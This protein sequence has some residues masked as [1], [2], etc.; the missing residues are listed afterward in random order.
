MLPTASIKHDVTDK[1]SFGIIFEKPF[2]A[3]VAYGPSSIL[4]AGTTASADT[5]SITALFRYKFSDRISIHGG[6]C[7]QSAEA[8]FGLTGAIYGPF[9]GYTANMARDQRLGYVVG[10]A[11]EIP[12]YFLRVALTYSSEIEHSFTTTETSLFGALVS[13]VSA[14]TPQ[15]INLD[16]NTGVASET[17]IFGGA[18]WVEWSK[19]QV[20]PSV[21]SGTSAS[22][23]VNFNDTGTYS[24]GI[25]RQFSENWTGT[26][27]LIYEPST[28]PLTTPLAPTDG[29]YGLSI[30]AVYT[31]DNQQV[32][33]NVVATRQGD[34]TPFV[35]DLGTTVTSFSGN[36]T[37]GVG[38]KIVQKFWPSLTSDRSCCRLERQPAV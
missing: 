13:E 34:A 9:S 2:G 18:R 15:S 32:H 8:S 25:G 21:L 26:A 35:K 6:P 23:M 36:S 16:F 11:F 17:F 28:S 10:A 30:G 3:E 7:W 29:F 12:E 24:F 1:L 14:T 4:F 38:F 22:P 19:L 27:A 37:L 33:A 31:R 20:A 5:S